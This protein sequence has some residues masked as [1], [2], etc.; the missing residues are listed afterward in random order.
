MQEKHLSHHCLLQIMS[1]TCHRHIPKLISP[2]LADMDIASLKDV[3]I[4]AERLLQA[5]ERGERI[6]L[7]KTLML[8]YHFSGRDEACAG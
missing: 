1:T 4:A 2:S 5:K 8:W 6:A 7:A 3:D